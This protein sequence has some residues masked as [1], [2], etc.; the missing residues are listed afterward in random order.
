MCLLCRL[1]CRKYCSAVVQKLSLPAQKSLIHI[2]IHGWGSRSTW[3]SLNSSE[4]ISWQA[5]R[6]LERVSKWCSQI[7]LRE[8]MNKRASIWNPTLVISSELALAHM[9]RSGTGWQTLIGSGISH[10]LPKIAGESVDFPFIVMAS[11]SIS[12]SKLPQRP[13]VFP[14]SELSSSISRA[15]LPFHLI[16]VP[17]PSTV[18]KSPVFSKITPDLTE[19]SSISFN[20]N[21]PMK[22]FGVPFS[23]RSRICWPAKKIL[24][25]NDFESY[26]IRLGNQGLRS[27]V[28]KTSHEKVEIAPISILAALGAL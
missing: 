4:A 10:E 23:C 2:S 1:H 18:M 24:I 6:A 15:E 8:P 28:V 25:I 12:P 13:H 26:E 11:F 27:E 9:G 3:H 21:D 20:P 19:G 17:N 22:A 7:Y 14:A 5:V 16:D